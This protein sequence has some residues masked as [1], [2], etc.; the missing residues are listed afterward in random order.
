MSTVHV[1]RKDN[2]TEDIMNIFILVKWEEKYLH[3]DTVELSPR[4][5]GFGADLV[6]RTAVLQPRRG[7][8][9][10]ARTERSVG[11]ALDEKGI[12]IRPRNRRNCA[13][14]GSLQRS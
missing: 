9:L 14:S 10:S 5:L 6:T 2:Q 12:A 8:P 13:L 4:R 11:W 3:R 7:V 1:Q